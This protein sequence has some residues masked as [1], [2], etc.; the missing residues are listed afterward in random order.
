MKLSI[1]TDLLST[2]IDT[3]ASIAD[4]IESIKTG[5]LKDSVMAIRF[6]TDSSQRKQLKQHLPLFYPCIYLSGFR[7]LDLETDYKSTGL[8]QFDIDDISPAEIEK[9]RHKLITCVPE[10]YYLFVSPS[11]NG[12]KFAIATDFDSDDKH[13]REE[14]KIVYRIASEY[15]QSVIDVE[16]D[17]SVQAINQSCY[18]SHD[19]DAFINEKAKVLEVAEQASLVRIENE[20]KVIGTDFVS[21]S[22]DEDEVLKALS[23][24]PA[25][26]KYNE[27]YSINQAVISVFG[28]YAEKVLLSHWSHDDKSKLQSDIH[29]Q[30]AGF[31][32]GKITVG[33]LFKEAEK[34]GY[35][36]SQQNQKSKAT[37]LAPTFNAKPLPIAEAQKVLEDV[38]S[39][40]LNNNQSAL[41]NVEAGAGKTAGVIDAIIKFLEINPLKKVAFFVPT[42]A[43]ADEIKLKLVERMDVL[44]KKFISRVGITHVRG[45]DHDDFECTLPVVAQINNATDENT[46][47]RLKLIKQDQQSRLCLTCQDKHCC[48]YFSQ[49]ENL[50]NNI[51]IYTHNTL[52]Q[53]PSIWD[54][55]W[56]MDSVVDM[57][58]DDHS[59][60]EF[61]AP[62]DPWEPDFIVVDEDVIS[63]HIISKDLV[64][65]TDYSDGNQLIK[66]II[67]E[68]GTY[69][70]D[71]RN[72]VNGLEHDIKIARKTQR[73]ELDNWW[74]E[75]KLYDGASDLDKML[76]RKP[77]Q[78]KVLDGLCYMLKTLKGNQD[79][80]CHQ[81]FVENDALVYAQRAKIH[82]RFKDVPTLLLDA[83]S[84]E[85]IAKA[86]FGNKIEFKSIRVKYQSNV[87]VIQFENN[88]FSKN[89]LMDT[90]TLNKA[91]EFI[92]ANSA[93]LKW[94]LITY[95]NLDGDPFAEKLADE[96]GADAVGWFGNCRGINAFEDLDALFVL[97]RYMVPPNILEM[98]YRQLFGGY[99]YSEPDFS[100]FKS[101]KVFRMSD[102]N[103]K[104]VKAYEWDSQRMIA[105]ANHINRAETYQAAHRLR[106]IHGDKPKKLYLMSS[107]VLDITVDELLNTDTVFGKRNKLSEDRIAEIF[108]AVRKLGFLYNKNSVIASETSMSPKDV[109]NL[110]R[111]SR[112]DQLLKEAGISVRTFTGINKQRKAVKRPFFVVDS[113]GP[114]N[115]ELGFIN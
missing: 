75:C 92:K 74:K 104:Q 36:T 58:S 70:K 86:A 81:I 1:S 49:Y 59:E 38:I 61:I 30:I 8:A 91:K 7:S 57:L 54:G 26:F 45:R 29:N 62:R 103:H 43:L 107:D 82:D 110:K 73:R 99:S 90:A 21:G 64:E 66:T 44:K 28:V 5:T 55:G 114:T 79:L 35:K 42:H 88:T 4:I 93:G 40:F 9:I 98:R 65:R 60:V 105:L 51:R 109:A 6:E 22:I 84:D 27:R 56:Q 112:L 11:G 63:N 16:L 17:D 18:F 68:V 72:V 115:D 80:Y 2:K 39:E 83:S 50:I 67:S 32:S 23:F 97:G 76:K 77:K 46:I 25:T 37:D 20:M 96:L 87:E 10:L 78:Y 3:H 13:I 52:F 53:K 33:T 71:I 95:L 12:L 31:K 85:L 111:S 15:I 19:P 14:F 41:V 48:S 113:Y 101:S 94:G 24:I 89:A 100:S 47:K 108:K 69:G 102:G 106:L 34:H